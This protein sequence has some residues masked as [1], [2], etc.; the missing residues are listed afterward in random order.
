MRRGKMTRRRTLQSDARWPANAA[1]WVSPRLP[2]L[3][4]GFL[5]K[6][7]CFTD[8]TRP[9]IV[10][11]PGSFTVGLNMLETEELFGIGPADFPPVVFADRAGIEPRAGLVRRF[12]RGIHREQHAV[13][14]DLLQRVQQGRGLKHAGGGDVEVGPQVFRQ[15]LL[16]VA[17]GA[18][19]QVPQ[20]VV[21]PGQLE[22]EHLAHVPD[23][24]VNAGMTVEQAGQHQPQRVGSGFDIETPRRAVQALVALVGPPHA[25]QRRP[26]MQVDRD[27][28]LFHA[29]P[30]RFHLR[31]VEV[32]RG[33]LVPDVAEAVNQG[34]DEAQV[35]DSPFEFVSAL[36][37]IL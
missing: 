20:P 11:N 13:G 26:G 9:S 17:V 19:T 4:L 14:A 24:D 22:R 32:Q 27:A 8:R 1:S 23:D 2:F 18:G 6:L 37:R 3:P 5:P 33:V 34:T 30:E 35:P 10:R 31:F 28:E 25:R 12:P 7:E 16:V 21:Y 29:R 36:L 15:E